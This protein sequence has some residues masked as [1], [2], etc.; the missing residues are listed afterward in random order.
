MTT[1]SII[2]NAAGA[3]AD[4]VAETAGVRPLGV[5]PKRRTAVIV[6]A[7]EG[8][9][10]TGVPMLV[11]I[12]ERFYVKPEA[13]RLLLSPADATPTPPC[14]VQPDEM[15]IAVAVDRV[16]QALDISVRRVHH[17]WAGLRSFV[18]D[19]VPVVGFGAPSF[20]WLAGQGGY[21]IQTAPAMAMLAAAMIKGQA[22]PEIISREGLDPEVLSPTRSGLSAIDP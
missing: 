9:D 21:G 11:D 16:M 13:G 8:V 12:E 4:E 19:G 7:P 15:D 20:F 6:D 18:A 1:A 2:V 10:L 5:I 14:D 17:R 3:W 22:V